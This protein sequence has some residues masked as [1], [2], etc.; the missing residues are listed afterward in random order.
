MILQESTY[1]PCPP[2]IAVAFLEGMDRHYRA[3]HPDHVDFAWLPSPRGPHGRFRFEERIGRWQLHLT[4]RLDGRSD[5]RAVYIPENRFVRWAFPGMSFEILPE[6]S[7]CRWTHRIALR[8]AF[9]APMLERTL[10]GPLRIHMREE[11]ANLRQ[12]T[13]DPSVTLLQ[14]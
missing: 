9:F 5:L 3:W 2:A 14:Q 8:L 6:G 4:M 10:L 13:A 7:G 1:L 12:L 11:T